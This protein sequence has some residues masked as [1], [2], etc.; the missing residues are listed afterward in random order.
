MKTTAEK[1]LSFFCLILMPRQGSFKG[2][3]DRGKNSAILGDFLL[4]N[5]QIAY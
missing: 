2:G 3:A 4:I 5:F 1:R